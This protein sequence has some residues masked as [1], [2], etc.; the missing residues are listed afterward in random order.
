MKK[1][2]ISFFAPC[3]FLAQTANLSAEAAASAPAEQGFTQ[4]LVMISIALLFFYFILWRP[5]QKKRKEVETQRNSMKKGDRVV[6]MGI[7]G[8]ISKIKDDTV[9][10]R[11]VDGSEIEFLKAAISSVNPA[12]EAVKKEES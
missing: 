7:I 6:A 9:I 11:M 12:S 2:A 10:V 4:T 1:F 5:E 3:L 8:S